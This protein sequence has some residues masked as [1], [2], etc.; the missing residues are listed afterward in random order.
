MPSEAQ[1]GH[2][3]EQAAEGGVAGFRCQD[4]HLT[5]RVIVS[6]VTLLLGQ[7]H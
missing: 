1:R 7:Q 4:R 6:R 3:E 5:A 2:Q